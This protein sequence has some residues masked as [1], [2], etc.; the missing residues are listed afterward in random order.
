[1][2]LTAAERGKKQNQEATVAAFNIGICIRAWEKAESKHKHE[3][4][5]WDLLIKTEIHG[6]SLCDPKLR[7][8]DLAGVGKMS[9]ELLKPKLDKLGKKQNFTSAN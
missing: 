7:E 4:R 8:E 5:A 3:A 6:L 1:M 2:C 9:N